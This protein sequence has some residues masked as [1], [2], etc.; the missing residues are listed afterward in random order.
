[1][2]DLSSG[3]GQRSSA[4]AVSKSL[5]MAATLLNS[6]RCSSASVREAWRRAG[7]TRRSRLVEPW[8]VAVM[9]D[10]LVQRFT[11]LVHEN[12]LLGSCDPCHISSGARKVEPPSTGGSPGDPPGNGYN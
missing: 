11:I 12:M 5:T 8:N 10:L 9:A 3:G 7:A 2:S 6:R 4:V 1:M